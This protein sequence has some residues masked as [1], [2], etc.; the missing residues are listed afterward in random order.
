VVATGGVYGGP[1]EVDQSNG[2]PSVYYEGPGNSL[3]E[4]WLS[5]SGWNFAGDI[6][7][8]AVF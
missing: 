5:G 1:S 8:N 4:A 2:Y 3:T 7:S 6:A